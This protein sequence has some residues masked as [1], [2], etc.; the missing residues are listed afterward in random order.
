MKVFINNS[1]TCDEIPV[2]YV[3]IDQRLK[4]ETL[5]LEQYFPLRRLH[6]CKWMD[7]SVVTP[8]L[9]CPLF[10]E[11]D[12]AP[13]DQGLHNPNKSNLPPN[14]MDTVTKPVNTTAA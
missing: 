13:V 2:L 14:K 3:I 5:L 9:C 8:D 11:P 6:E 12:A 1:V 10:P 7:V 4:W